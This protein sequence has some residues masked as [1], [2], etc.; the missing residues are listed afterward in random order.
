MNI[1]SGFDKFSKEGISQ[2]I[3]NLTVYATDTIGIICVIFIL[4]GAIQ[5]ITS[6]GN[7]EQ[8]T[9]ARSTLTW[10]VVGLILVIGARL[11]VD[12]L[13]NFVTS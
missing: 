4:V 5:M 6:S 12:Y 7:Q 13:K 3:D 8:V 10:A 11:F 2:F 1:F 9:K